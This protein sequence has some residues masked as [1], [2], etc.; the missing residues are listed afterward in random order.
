MEFLSAAILKKEFK[1]EASFYQ[2]KVGNK[3]YQCRNNAVIMR[4]D[5]SR[6]DQPDAVIVMANPGSCSPSE[7]SYVAPVVQGTITNIEYVSVADDQTQQQL[8]R[9]M[10]LMDWNVIS[11]INLSDLCTGKMDKFGEVLNELEGY[12]F[13]SHSIFSEDRNEEREK[14][15]NDTNSKLILAWGGNSIIR[16][17][18]CYALT[19]LPEERLVYGLPGTSKW[20]FR[21]PFPRIKSRCEAWLKDMV[22]QLKDSD[23]KS[24]I[25]ATKDCNK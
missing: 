23:S 8:M 10:K 3:K 19:K 4:H 17:L 15:F 25:A 9:L 2:I 7:N 24:Q 12:N 16:E 1:V 22:E 13:K 18:A 5:F 21:H 20:E 11:I 6:D 14:L